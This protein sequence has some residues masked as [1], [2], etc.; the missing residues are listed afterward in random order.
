MKLSEIKNQLKNLTK[1]AFQLP[2]GDL[3]PN[4]FSCNGSGK[5][6]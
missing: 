1:I 4:H 3:V 6:Y 2:N 5:N